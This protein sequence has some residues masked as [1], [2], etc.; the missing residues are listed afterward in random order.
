ML[1]HYKSNLQAKTSSLGSFIL[2]QVRI[3]CNAHDLVVVGISEEASSWLDSITQ[4]P[5]P[6]SN[7]S[8]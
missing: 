3:M 2:P 4:N 6:P 5:P 7:I 8:K 1:T